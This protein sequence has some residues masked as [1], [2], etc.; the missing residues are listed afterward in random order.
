MFKNN[1]PLQINF[2]LAKKY[3]SSFEKNITFANGI[4]LSFNNL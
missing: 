3:L 4:E 2:Q 1:L